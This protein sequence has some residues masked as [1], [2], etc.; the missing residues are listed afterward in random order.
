MLN[1]WC[2]FL[3]SL[4]SHILPTYFCKPALHLSAKPLLVAFVCTDDHRCLEE[5]P[6]YSL[7]DSHPCRKQLFLARHCCW[8]F[9]PKQDW[10]KPLLC[11]LKIESQNWNRPAPTSKLCPRGVLCVGCLPVWQSHSTA[12][13]PT[14]HRPL[15]SRT[16][17]RHPPPPPPPPSSQ[18]RSEGTRCSAEKCPRWTASETWCDRTVTST[19]CQLFRWS[20]IRF[21]SVWKTWWH[22]CP[23]LPPLSRCRNGLKGTHPPLITHWLWLFFFLLT[24]NDKG[25]ACLLYIRHMPDIISPTLFPNSKAH[26]CWCNGVTGLPQFSCWI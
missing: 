5:K 4:K 26:P 9:P 22:L 24:A 23:D 20:A 6:P 11:T 19:K 17:S 1:I 21:S 3:T 14:V 10:G 8:C 16:P 7:S 25:L 18:E 15:N 12:H 13:R 2:R